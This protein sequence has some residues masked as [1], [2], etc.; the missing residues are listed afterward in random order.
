MEGWASTAAQQQQQPLSGHAAAAADV[1]GAVPQAPEVA[2]CSAGA[3]PVRAGRVGEAHA[4]LQAHAGST[5]A[6]A[7]PKAR[8]SKRKLVDP[9]QYD[10]DGAIVID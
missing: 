10:A 4:Q 3:R 9:L 5:A 2:P 6:A 1:R 8:R 7:T